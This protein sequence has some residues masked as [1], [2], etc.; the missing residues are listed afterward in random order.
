MKK[1]FLFIKLFSTLPA[2]VQLFQLS[3]SQFILLHCLRTEFEPFTIAL[4][5]TF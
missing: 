2:S 5:H 1:K 3:T 4:I